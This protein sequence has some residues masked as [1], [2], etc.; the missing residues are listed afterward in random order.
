VARS[1]ELEEKEKDRKHALYDLWCESVVL[2]SCFPCVLVFLLHICF[3]FSGG[4]LFEIDCMISITIA[5]RGERGSC[6]DG[7]NYGKHGK[8]IIY[9]TKYLLCWL[10]PHER[11]CS[12]VAFSLITNK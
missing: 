5:N 6:N 4:L 8:A 7:I 11:F 12:F 9:S 1:L 2:F 3:I 10:G